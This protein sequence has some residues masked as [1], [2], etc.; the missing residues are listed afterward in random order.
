MHSRDG[1]A[2]GCRRDDHIS[3]QRPRKLDDRISS[4]QVYDDSEERL[5]SALQAVEESY[6]RSTRIPI[7]KIGSSEPKVN[8]L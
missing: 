1:A 8:S 7:L 5:L 4:N 2:H 6:I 3:S